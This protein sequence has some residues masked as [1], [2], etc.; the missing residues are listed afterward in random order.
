MVLI[1]DCFLQSLALASHNYEDHLSDSEV[2]DLLSRVRHSVVSNLKCA[3]N[4]SC[5][6]HQDTKAT[7]H[8]CFWESH[9]SVCLSVCLSVRSSVRLFVCV[10]VCFLFVHF[11]G[12]CFLF[13]FCIY[14]I[15]LLCPLPNYIA[16]LSL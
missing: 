13:Y 12:H 2:A 4:A 14:F 1:S 8:L 5:L 7:N 6:A 3:D 16:N 11:L 10:F 15:L 9:M